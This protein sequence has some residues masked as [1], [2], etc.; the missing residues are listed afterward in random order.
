[1]AIGRIRCSIP[2]GADHTES[3]K[4]NVSNRLHVAT[5]KGL[6]T[7]ERRQD[8]WR[9]R[10]VGFL[11]D[12]VNMVLEDPRDGRPY[13]ALGHGHF[14]Q[15]LHASDDGGETWQEISTPAYPPKPENEPEVM[16]PIRNRPIPWRLELIWALEAAGPDQP[17][18]IWCGTAPGGLFRSDDRGQSW[19]LN[20]PLWEQPARR[21]W[22]GGG[23][24]YPG[25]HSICI[26]PGDSNRITI[27]ISCGGVWVTGDGGKSWACR[28]KGMFAE[29]VPPESREDPDIQDPHRC[30]QCPAAPDTCWVAHHNGVFRTTNGCQEWSEVTAIQP[31]RFGFAV[32]VHP[33]RPDTAWFVP[34]LRDE[35]R[36]PVDG[37]VVVA[38]TRDGGSSFEVLREGLPQEHAYDLT[39]RH[40]LDVDETG[41]RL[42]FGST[43]GSLWISENGGD[44]WKHISAHLPPIYAV[45]FAK[46]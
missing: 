40:A 24:E 30:V 36:I 20:R 42:A 1:M 3:K 34:A 26:H 4:I 5:R 8:C 38:R 2:S 41:E 44:S 16:D 37:R 43:T 21:K 7:L 23:F 39:L 46:P 13:A 27:A 29:Y 35:K 9:I 45:R 32:A 33:H 15:K 11:G 31:S 14:G 18:V 25:I 10:N 17:G 12:P 6:F 22:F 19:T 28:S